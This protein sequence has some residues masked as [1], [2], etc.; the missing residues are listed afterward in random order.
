MSNRAHLTRTKFEDE[1]GAGWGWRLSDDYVRSYCDHHSES[2]VPTEPLK[3]LAKAAAE[4]NDEESELFEDLLTNKKGI[5]LNGDWHEF[6][7]IAP[8]L[9]KALYGEE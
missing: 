6:D 2:E 1:A 4:A 5:S 8:I 9:R 7:Q 3:L